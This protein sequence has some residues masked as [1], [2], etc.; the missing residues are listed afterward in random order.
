MSI[1]TEVMLVGCVDRKR[2]GFDDI[3]KQHKLEKFKVIDIDINDMEL[4]VAIKINGRK[5]WLFVSEFITL[6]LI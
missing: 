4:P 3:I 5:V 1:G 6:D 2:E